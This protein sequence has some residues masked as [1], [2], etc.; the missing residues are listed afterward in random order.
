M[1]QRHCLYVRTCVDAS[2][3]D[4][5]GARRHQY[6]SPSYHIGSLCG[7]CFAIHTTRRLLTMTFFRLALLILLLLE[8]ISVTTALAS[9]EVLS[10]RQAL[11]SAAATGA[12]LLSIPPPAHAAEG[13]ASKLQKRDPALLKNS[14]FNVPPSAQVYPKFMRGA[15]FKVTSKFNGYIFPSEKIPKS[16]LTQDFEVPGFQ[17]CSIA[18]I[19][20]VGKEV[21]EYQ[22]KIDAKGLEDRQFTLKSQVDAFLGYPAV[23]QVLYDA[24]RNPNRISIDFIEYKTRNAERI[25]L[26]CNA[27]ESELYAN[28]DEQQVF[29]CSS[30]FDK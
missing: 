16:R 17:K 9:T 29:V 27:R 3:S 13:L 20:D 30:T 14:V 25:E 2:V 8:S 18:A 1:Y 10:R 4:A 22:M 5:P 21:A 28:N 15:T 7:R 24:P 12:S 23:A 11:V 19:C 6:Q 26:F